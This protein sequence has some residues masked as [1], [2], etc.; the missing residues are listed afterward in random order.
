M[1]LTLAVP[2]A[3]IA[4]AKAKSKKG[5]RDSSIKNSLTLASVRTPSRRSVVGVPTSL[6]VVPPEVGDAGSEDGDDDIRPLSRHEL[7]VHR[8]V[9][10]AS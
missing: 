7:E 3:V 4:V 1:P 5:K 2:A 10:A 6:T 8:K 9:Q